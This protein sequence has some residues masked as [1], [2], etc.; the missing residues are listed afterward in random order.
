MLDRGEGV[1]EISQGIVDLVH[2]IGFHDSSL[3]KQLKSSDGMER[4]IA[5]RQVL[6]ER[7][8]FAMELGFEGHFAQVLKDIEITHPTGL[9]E[10]N[11]L[12]Q[13]LESF[14]VG[15]MQNAQVLGEGQEKTIRHLSLAGIPF[16]VM[17]GWVGLRIQNLSHTGR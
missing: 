10:E 3:L 2:S 16:Q 14:E 4:L 7:D 6:S 12:A 8:S 15:M 13:L 9:A 5:L 1:E 11:K 17:P